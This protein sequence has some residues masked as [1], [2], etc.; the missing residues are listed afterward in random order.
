MLGRSVF[1]SA[2]A[3]LAFAVSALGHD[4]WLA[5]DSASAPVGQEVV[6]RLFRGEAPKAD[7]ERPFE[8]EHTER[9]S[10]LWGEQKLDLKAAAKDGGMPV[11][12]MTPKSEGGHL[13][14]MERRP[15]TIMLEADKIEAYLRDEGLDAVIARREE[16]GEAR[17]ANATA[18]TSK[19]WSRSRTVAT[20][21]IV[22]R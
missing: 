10:L 19:P 14:A 13:I 12:R 5:P 3:N 15:A 21:P 4:Y 16:L 18:G 2:I 8:A 17:V 22:A 1:I 7:D 11:A 20:R 9:F 6:V